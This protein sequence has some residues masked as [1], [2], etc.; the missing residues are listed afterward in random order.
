M[1]APP[2]RSE[3]NKTYYETHKEQIKAYR[4]ANKEKIREYQRL[5][6][7][8]C[9]KTKEREKN[10]LRYKDRKEKKAKEKPTVERILKGKPK[11]VT[12]KE[13]LPPPKEIEI[14]IGTFFV[15]FA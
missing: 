15:S 9:D 13:L 7:Q 6:Y 5:Y 2:D 12:E 3:W 11:T 10:A 14:K 8:N 4:A 1:S